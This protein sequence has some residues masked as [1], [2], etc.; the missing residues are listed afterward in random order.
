MYKQLRLVLLFGLV[1]SSNIL[2]LISNSYSAGFQLFEG[3]AINVGDFGAGGAANLNDASATF[4]NPAA[5]DNVKGQQITVAATG[6]FRSMKFTGD[7]TLT[8]P[9]TDDGTE[10]TEVG[11]NATLKVNEFDPVPALFY[12]IPVNEKVVVGAGFS[13]PFGLATNWPKKSIMRY[14]AT[15]S[16][17]I[18][19]N[20]GP[21]FSYRIHPK[22]VI[23]GGVDVQFIKA[24]L[25]SAIRRPV[26]SVSEGK[27][28]GDN[29]SRNSAHGVG[30]G[31]NAG[32]LIQVIDPLTISVHYR[33]RISHSLSG[34][35]N[36][37]GPLDPNGV[38]KSDVSVDVTIPDS[39]SIS[40]AFKATKRLTVMASA[41]YTNWST[42]KGLTLKNIASPGGPVTETIELNFKNTWRFVGGFQ[43]QINHK[44]LIR[45]GAG[46]DPTP[47]RDKNRSARLPDSNRVAV[48]IGGQY[49]LSKR[50][51]FDVGY[52]HLFMKKAALDHTVET[53]SQ[54]STTKGE[55]Q[56]S[57]DLLSL[58]VTA[59]IG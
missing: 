20:F 33:S 47:T 58:Q 55:V 21:G 34:T 23:G 45:S 50:F 53:S 44:F 43:F 27:F 30:F 9:T 28:L 48:S 6:I 25:D 16:K 3:N 18:T 54:T 40:S 36:F 15:K 14:A 37:D 19:I 1:I 11:K 24:T 10:T 51:I 12:A 32:V 39:I 2:F 52:T 8:Q 56:S 31:Y 5:L 22:L 59:N 42:I 7:T 41:Y 4:F 57:A 35:S 17:I 46:F 29:F 26:D 49:K 13:A 38:A